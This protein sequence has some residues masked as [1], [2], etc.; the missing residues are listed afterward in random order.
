VT[1]S[2]QTACHI[3]TICPLLKGLEKMNKIHLS[4]ARYKNNLYIAWI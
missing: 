4:G 2:F 1:F 3:N